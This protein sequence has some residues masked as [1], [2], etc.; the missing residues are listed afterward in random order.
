MADVFVTLKIM[1][2]GVDVNLNELKTRAGKEILA[3]K[4]RIIKEEI[5]P[6]AFGLNAVKL[7]LAYEESRGGTDEIEAKI[8]RLKD[9]ESV[10]VVDVRRAIG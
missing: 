10:D 2:A 4:G 3:F 1:P 7:T 6:I 8:A 5:E 9:V